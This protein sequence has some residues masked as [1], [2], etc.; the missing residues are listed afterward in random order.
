VSDDTRRIAARKREI[1]GDEF[2]RALTMG[3]AY[4]ANHPG[5]A[6]DGRPMYAAEPVL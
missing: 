6:R 5:R 2:R 3:K 4:M 1:G